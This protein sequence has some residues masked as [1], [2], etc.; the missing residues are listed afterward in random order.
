MRARVGCADERPAH[1]RATG[2]AELRYQAFYCEENVFHLCGHEVLAG[3]R[4]HAVVISGAHE[5]FVMWHQRA[6]R[7]PGGALFWDYHVIVLAEEPWEIWDLDT[8]LGFPVPAGE[9]L[10]RSFRDGLPA[11]LAPIFRVVP[12]QVFVATLAVGSTAHARGPTGATRGH[13]LLVGADQRAGAR[14]E[15]DAVRRHA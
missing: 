3:R 5:G 10:A 11:E 7:R 12:A 6:A 15:P 13:C 1:A 4:R 2:P 14:I 9:Y 8:T